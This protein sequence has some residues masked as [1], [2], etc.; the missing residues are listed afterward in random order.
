[1]H[2]IFLVMSVFTTSNNGYEMANMD[3]PSCLV[4]VVIYSVLPVSIGKPTRSLIHPQLEVALSEQTLL[5][6]LSLLIIWSPAQVVTYH[7][8]LVDHCCINTSIALFG[9]IIIASSCLA[10][11]KNIPTPVRQSNP[12]RL[13]SLL[14]LVMMFKSNMFTLITECLPPQSLLSILMHVHNAVIFVASV[15]IA[16]MVLSNNTLVLLQTK[17][18]QCFC[19]Q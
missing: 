4:I 3:S 14:P 6:L 17:L 7:Y 18:I 8:M 2:T 10:T 15:L 16:K 5:M 19:M 11:Y 9:P 13:L 12:K 1:M